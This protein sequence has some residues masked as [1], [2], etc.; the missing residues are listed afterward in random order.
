V[1]TLADRLRDLVRPT[2]VSGTPVEAQHDHA[3]DVLGG[4]WE[5]H[6]SR[7]VLVVDRRYG[8][9]H[10]H[11]RVSVADCL[12]GDS[13]WATLD[14]LGGR[15]APASGVLFLDLE[16]TGLAGGA[17]TYAFLVGCGWFDDTSFRLRQFFLPSAAAEA[18]LLTSLSSLIE[19]SGCVCLVTY[20]GKTFDV[21]VIDTRC[22]LQRLEPPFV[23][24][25][26]VDMLHHARRLW[27]ESPDPGDGAAQGCR[28]TT[29]ERA[30][31]GHEREGDVPGFEIPGRY[32]HFVRTGDAAP[33]VPVLEHN[34]LDILALAALTARAAQVL[35]GAPDSATPREA[36]GVARLLERAGRTDEALDWYSRAGQGRGVRA[37]AL[38][39]RALLLRRLRRYA[40]AADAW[41][42]V[43]G[44]RCPGASS[45]GYRRAR[46]PPRAPGARPARRPRV[47]I[48][49]AR[50][51]GGTRQT[52][53]GTASPRPA[54]S[55]A[56]TID[57]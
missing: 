17:G 39:A 57:A 44:V 46:R 27:A 34:R 45:G 48:A 19:T 14:L 20:N 5:G 10:R 55:Q 43:L 7:R 1:S 18:A 26:H 12:P 53:C 24:L 51:R 31:C 49:G 36:L 52:R 32:F 37:D 3:A 28:L 16:T 35:G 6:A 29:L 50:S 38:R 9:G 4:V 41:R 42:D 25:V 30:L 2:V 21:P 47:C 22:V 23:G 15:A 8:P 33:L 13:G 56:A 54:R 11:G 40:D